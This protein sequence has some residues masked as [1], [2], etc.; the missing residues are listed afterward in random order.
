VD[1]DRIEACVRR[2]LDDAQTYESMA[3]VRDLYGDGRASERIVKD[4]MGYL[5][6]THA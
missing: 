3:K 2:L 1:A 5:R 6:I 4:V